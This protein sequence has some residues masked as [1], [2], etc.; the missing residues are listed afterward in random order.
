MP[1]DHIYQLNV[2]VGVFNGED[3]TNMRTIILG[4]P[5]KFKDKQTLVLIHGFAG[6]GALFYK[7]FKELSEYFQVIIIDLIGMGGSSRPD[8]YDPE[9]FD[10]Q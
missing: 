4:D 2:N 10:P 6:S 5:T 3:K 9:N 1:S 7:I 8:N